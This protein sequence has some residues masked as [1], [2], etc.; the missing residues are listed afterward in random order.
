MKLDGTWLLNND[1]STA[2]YMYLMGTM[3]LLVMY[4]AEL[5]SKGIDYCNSRISES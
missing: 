2:K 5:N 3:I 1:T 4:V